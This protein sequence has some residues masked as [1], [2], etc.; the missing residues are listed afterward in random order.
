MTYGTAAINEIVWAG[1]FVVGVIVSLL[2][3]ADAQKT[4]HYLQAAGFNGVRE[5]IARGNVI[6]EYHRLAINCIAVMIGVFALASEPINKRD[7]ISVLSLVTSVGLI[8]IGVLIQAGSIT[9]RRRRNHGIAMLMEASRIRV[10]AIPE[11]IQRDTE[12]IKARVI[13][14]EQGAEAIRNTAES[15]Q[16]GQADADIERKEDAL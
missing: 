15:I 3:L 1:V 8:V 12:A 16:Q 4:L 14:V 2:A 10:E 11:Q 6:N 5:L 7:P 9:D 13:E